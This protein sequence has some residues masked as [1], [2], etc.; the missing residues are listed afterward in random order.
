MAEQNNKTHVN[1]LKQQRIISGMTQLQLAEK[2]GISIRVIQNYE[3]NHR[4]INKAQALI[5]WKLAKALDCEV[6]DI[7]NDERSVEE[8]G[9]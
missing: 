1:N 6:G 9:N 3:S 2:S 7:L 8:L 4:D 5:V